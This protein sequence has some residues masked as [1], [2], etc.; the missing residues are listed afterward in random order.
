MKTETMQRESL[1]ACTL[2]IL[3]CALGAMGQDAPAAKPSAKKAGPTVA[4]AKRFLDEA[5]QRYLELTNK[6]QRAQW[7]QENFITDDTE[8]IGAEAGQELQPRW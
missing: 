5:E 8:E 6:A 7:V 4:E 1:I 2:A 3:I